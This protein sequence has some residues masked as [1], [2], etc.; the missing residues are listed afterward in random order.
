MTILGIFEVGVVWIILRIVII[1]FG[2]KCIV[3]GIR[4]L[5]E[6]TQI[7]KDGDD[8]DDYNGE[9]ERKERRKLAGLITLSYLLPIG[10]IVLGVVLILGP[11]IF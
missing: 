4:G 9:E 5:V 1:V 7:V 2:V 3:S 6:V 11:I 8:D 10:E